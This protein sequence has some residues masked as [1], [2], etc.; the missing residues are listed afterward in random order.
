MKESS[1]SSVSPLST[2]DSSKCE[3]VL[4]VQDVGML[5]QL[6]PMLF[7]GVELKTYFEC[8]VCYEYITP[9][10]FQC[11]RGHLVCMDCFPKLSSCPTCR[12]S[13]QVCAR[14]LMMEK[15]SNCINFPCKYAH[16]GCTEQHTG[17]TKS[18]H[19]L[20]CSHL[21]KHLQTEHNHIIILEG[22]EVMFLV[23]NIDSIGVTTWAMLQKVYG[24][25]F[26]I[27]LVKEPM[28]AQS[29]NENFSYFK[30]IIKII[31]MANDANSFKYRIDIAGSY[32]RIL[33]EDKPKPFLYKQLPVD[34]ENDCLIFDE[35]TA[36]KIST[37]GTIPIS[38]RISRS[39]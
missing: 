18:A 21:F 19:E 14:N 13:Y 26:L 15:M 31:G 22:E 4:P 35:Q 28:F 24:R 37:N 39:V 16:N 9:P 11:V 1:P 20:T 7:G 32:G 12:D 34:K 33:Y 30:L 36:K 8:P 25:E 5:E 3:T 27:F 10:I 2:D 17:A 29:T 23:T 6:D 38:I